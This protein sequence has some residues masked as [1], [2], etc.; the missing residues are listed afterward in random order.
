MR[1]GARL[2]AAGSGE[3]RC[4]WPVG[5]RAGSR[6]GFAARRF[7]G[8]WRKMEASKENGRRNDRGFAACRLGRKRPIGADLDG[9]RLAG[10]AQQRRDFAALFKP[11]AG[12]G[13][14][15]SEIWQVRTRQAQKRQQRQAHQ[16]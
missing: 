16:Q 8:R 14:G 15:A 7:G 5:T 13:V 4:A 12:A 1:V 10:E 3:R 11:D 6:R 9:L 2:A